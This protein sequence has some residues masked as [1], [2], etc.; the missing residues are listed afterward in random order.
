MQCTFIQSISVAAAIKQCLVSTVPLNCSQHFIFFLI[1]TYILFAELFSCW[2]YYNNIN[3]L[4]RKLSYSGSLIKNESNY[5]NLPPL[6]K[7]KVRNV[8]ILFTVSRCVQNYESNNY[9]YIYTNKT[10]E[11]LI[12][13][14]V[15]PLYP[16]N[17]L[18]LFYK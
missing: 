3:S 1:L 7:K 14:S 13:Q 16:A 11:N 5:G 9:L 6:D 18:N 8:Y 2:F 10:Y 12:E 4:I 15:M 17:F